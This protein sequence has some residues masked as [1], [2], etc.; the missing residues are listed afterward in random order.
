MEAVTWCSQSRSDV[1]ARVDERVELVDHLSGAVDGDDGDFDDPV[2]VVQAGRLH[3]DHG[4]TFRGG[5]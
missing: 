1:S 5:K 3:I 4:D 2:D